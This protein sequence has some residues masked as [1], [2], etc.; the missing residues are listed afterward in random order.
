MDK[1]IAVG[2]NILNSIITYLNN[3]IKCILYDN[4][5]FYCSKTYENFSII[6]FK[7]EIN[8]TI[9]LKYLIDKINIHFDNIDKLLFLAHKLNSSEIIYNNNILQFIFNK[10]CYSVEYDN[11][12][13]LDIET[14][15]VKFTNI[16]DLEDYINNM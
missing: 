14:C 13:T 16:N 5:Y 3:G 15:R 8:M 6:S 11:D 9:T 1:N 7:I 12:I 4:N 2:D 10:K